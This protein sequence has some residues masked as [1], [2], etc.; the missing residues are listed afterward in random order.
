MFIVNPKS[1]IWYIQR[2]LSH[3]KK[4]EQTHRKLER[5]RFTEGRCDCHMLT[6]WH[7]A[8][9]LLREWGCD[10]GDSVSYRI[11]NSVT[12]RPA[13]VDFCQTW[14]VALEKKKNLLDKM[15]SARSVFVP[16]LF[17]MPREQPGLPI[18]LPP[19][20]PSPHWVSVLVLV[21][22]LLFCLC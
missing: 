3:D 6:W 4:D 18:N 8:S 16:K 9:W 2:P 19:A 17:K 7:S 10:H 15:P 20:M 5:R 1:Y 14:E 13:E 22:S 21:A 11:R 12:L